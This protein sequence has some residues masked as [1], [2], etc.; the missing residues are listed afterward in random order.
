VITFASTKN[1]KMT[2]KFNKMRSMMCKI[3]TEA[4]IV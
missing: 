3:Y 4:A 2:I 1:E